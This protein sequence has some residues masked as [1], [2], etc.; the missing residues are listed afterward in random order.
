MRWITFEFDSQK[1]RIYT[2]DIQKVPHISEMDM[3]IERIIGRSP[4][5]SQM[6]SLEFFVGIILSD[7]TVALGLTQP[8]TEM[9]TGSIS[10]G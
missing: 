6:V 2:V 5:R 10:Q 7:R 9:S 4:V 1:E 3:I 8:L